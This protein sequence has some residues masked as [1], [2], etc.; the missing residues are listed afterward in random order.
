MDLSP[1][2]TGLPRIQPILEFLGGTTILAVLMGLPATLHHYSTLSVPIA[3][4]SYRRVLEAG[5]FPATL[6]VIFLIYLFW[7]ERKS[8]KDKPALFD[9]SSPA[10][11]FMVPAVLVLLTGLVAMY[12]WLSWAIGRGLVRPI[13]WVLDGFTLSDRWTTLIGLGFVIIVAALVVAR[14]RMHSQGTSLTTVEESA[15]KIPEAS[16]TRV[17]MIYGWLLKPKTLKH[18]LFGSLAMYLLLPP[19]TIL[20]AYL[21]KTTILLVGLP[22]PG[23]FAQEVLLIGGIFTGIAYAHVFSADLFARF[24]TSKNKETSEGAR[25][26]RRVTYTVFV[27]ACIT[28]YSL[29]IYP[30]L[31]RSYGGGHPEMLNIVT[32]SSAIPEHLKPLFTADDGSNIYIEDIQLI[33]KTTEE[34]IFCKVQKGTP[35]CFAIPNSSIVSMSWCGDS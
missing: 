19:A 17:D 31:P 24:A 21:T 9:L 35:T 13:E 32:N 8:S 12:V 20:F 1:Q 6:L 4:L 34:V 27:A 30:H 28:L 23:I 2:S 10:I 15:K 22:W 16:T 7:V 14:I 25:S 29:Y 11:P 26:A 18:S 5:I 33:D 3:L